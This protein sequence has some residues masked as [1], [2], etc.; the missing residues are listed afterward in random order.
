[1]LGVSPYNTIGHQ[2]LYTLRLAGL[3]MDGTTTQPEANRFQ[4]GETYKGTFISNSDSHVF[5][6]ITRRTASSVWFVHPHGNG[7]T[8]RRSISTYDNEESFMPFGRYSMAMW[9]GA[10]YKV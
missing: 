2:N 10:S 6:T 7:E 4:T 8:V 5:F 9:I 1:M 3:Y